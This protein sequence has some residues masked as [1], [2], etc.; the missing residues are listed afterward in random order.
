MMRVAVSVISVVMTMVGTATVCAQNYPT[1]LVRIVTSGAG[2]GGDL[3]ARII[4]RSLTTSS[5]QQAIVDNR[6]GSVVIPAELV[7]KAAPDGYTLL[8]FASTFWQL[9]FLQD[10]VS[11]DPVN[12]FSPITL[13][14][15]SPNV[16]VV[17]PSLPVTSVKGLITLARA[18][19]GELN[20]SSGMTAGAS[21][22]AAEL[23]K[24]MAR[25][26]IVRIPYKEQ[27]RAL[28]DLVGGHTQLMFST[29]VLVN[30]HTRSGRLRA[31]G[32]ASAQP[33]AVAPEL[34]TVAASGLPG[35]ES[36]SS[37][38]AFAPA[39][40]SASIIRLLNQEMGKALITA[41]TKKLF[42]DA[43]SEV[44][45]NSP[46]QFAA[47]MKSD[48]TRMGKVIKEAGIRAD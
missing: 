16:L 35:Y 42:L 9:P 4:A 25:V 20:Y 33:S 38:G 17:H 23:F 48:M 2:G 44:V 43:G 28:I 3:V 45:G 18:R 40:T 46:E 26:N 12:D 27:A 21:H 15:V 1:K 22:L 24:S 31:L 14:V 7:A 41:E 11:Y 39:K 30:P 13:A 19:P 10:K 8:V 6:G 36:A 29:A 34:P 32:V 47:D 5:G 37:I